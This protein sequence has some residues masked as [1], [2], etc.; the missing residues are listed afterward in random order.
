MSDHPSSADGARAEPAYG[1]TT[2]TP[3]Q[4]PVSSTTSER[5]QMP[6]PNRHQTKPSAP[7]ACPSTAALVPPASVPATSKVVPGPLRWLALVPVLTLQEA[8]VVSDVVSVC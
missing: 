1:C 5:T 8:G 6:S 7:V 4:S 2:G 3:S